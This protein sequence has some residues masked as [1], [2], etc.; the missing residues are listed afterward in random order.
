MT[1]G[2]YRIYNTRDSA[3]YIGS[4][5]DIEKRCRDH[6]GYLRKGTHGNQLLQNAFD[7]QGE[8]C[9]R[10]EVLEIEDSGDY[11]RLVNLEQLY[12]DSRQ[13]LLNIARKAFAS[14][15]GRKH[16]DLT[17]EQMSLSQRYFWDSPKGKESRAVTSERFQGNQH[18]KGYKFSEEFKR[19]MS[20]RLKGNQYGR[21]NKG[22]KKS[23]EHCEKI[24]AAKR[25][26]WA[27][28]TAGRQQ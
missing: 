16:S 4:A 7:E 23:P 24:A 6:L 20:K 14:M 10:W 28:Q 5:K 22:K 8:S 9:F 3:E 11:E 12:L 25:R 15:T 21:G 2:I 26:W 18:L 27:Q 1:R 13:P 19:S 17:R